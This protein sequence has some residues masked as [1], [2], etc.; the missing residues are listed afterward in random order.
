MRN[1]FISASIL[2]FASLFSSVVVA[3]EIGSI[4]YKFRL[5]GPNDKLIIE[6]FED[7]DFDGVT[8]YLGRPVIGGV[9][10]S[11]GLAEDPAF[12]S[13]ACRK[14]KHIEVGE[15][16]ENGQ[17]VFSKDTNPFFKEIQVV[18]FIDRKRKNLIYMVYSDKLIDGSPKNNISIVSYSE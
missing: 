6:A 9:I 17:E 15:S 16:I 4:D 8:C 1:T 14:T 7:P 10:G 13:V 3:E 5:A 2:F 18:R 12:A 11:V